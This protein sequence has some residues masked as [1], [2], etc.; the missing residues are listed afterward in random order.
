MQPVKPHEIDWPNVSHLWVMP[1]I[2]SDDGAGFMPCVVYHDD[3]WDPV[4]VT[5]DI[6]SARRAVSALSAPHDL[7]CA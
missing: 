2:T 6:A 4:A 7:S 5:F 3:T 1:C